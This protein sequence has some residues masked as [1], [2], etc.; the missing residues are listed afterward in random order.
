M[1]KGFSTIYTRYG[2]QGLYKGVSWVFLFDAPATIC[3]FL[4]YT[5]TKQLFSH[6][7][8]YHRGDATLS[9]SMIE[10]LAAIPATMTGCLF[11]TPQ[12]TIVQKAQCTQFY[13]T[14]KR[15]AQA[16]LL[17]EGLSGFWRGYF[18][19]LCTL[20]PMCSLFLANYEFS[21]RAYVYFMN[22]GFINNEQDMEHRRMINKDLETIPCIISSSLFSGI[23]AIYFTQP[24]DTLR[25]RVQTSGPRGLH[26]NY[27]E[28]H[29]L[30]AGTNPNMWYHMRVAYQNASNLMK[31]EG[32]RQLLR[33]GFMARLLST[34]PDLMG[35]IISYELFIKWLSGNYI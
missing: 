24:L 11:W 26:F 28:R 5:K 34:G 20:I 6:F 32:M 31:V 4:T 7:G 9:S 3:Y 25:C 13:N 21:K 8:Y 12:D 15:I 30:Y 19:N 27:I 17:R 16:I 35:G 22:D 33:K 10:G 14:P 29:A 2:I 1:I 18:I 23:L